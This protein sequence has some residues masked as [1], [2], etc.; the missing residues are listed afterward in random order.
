MKLMNVTTSSISKQARASS[1][2]LVVAELHRALQPLIEI[3]NINDEE[4]RSKYITTS[5][6]DMHDVAGGGAVL[7]TDD[8][9]DCVWIFVMQS[10]QSRL[11]GW[12]IKLARLSRSRRTYWCAILTEQWALNT[13]GD[14]WRAI[15][16][17][18]L[19]GWFRPGRIVEVHFSSALA[20]RLSRGSGLTAEVITCTIPTCLYKHGLGLC[21]SPWAAKH[22]IQALR[23]KKKV[24]LCQGG[25]LR[26]RHEINIT[27][28]QQQWTQHRI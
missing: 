23:E 16:W 3:S 24:I 28:L 9:K 21:D 26:Y 14:A 11:R 22:S 15:D 19:M 7:N 18:R 4:D 25:R 6:W 20:C 27:Q 10:S 1:C 8:G 2:I 17:T 5:P 13:V 12:F